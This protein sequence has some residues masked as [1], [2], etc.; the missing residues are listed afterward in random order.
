MQQLL[1]PVLHQLPASHAQYLT[2]RSF[3]P[4]LITQPF[5][6]GLT[7]AFAFAI[8]ACVVAAIASALTGRP[9]ANTH[10]TVGG[11]LAEAVGMPGE[12]SAPGAPHAAVAAMAHKPATE[13]RSVGGV[14]ISG[15]VYG[16]D[17][18]PVTG[19]AVTLI[20]VEGRQLGRSI[21]QGDGSFAIDVP[22]RGSYVLIASA[23]GYQPQA[24][25]IVIADTPVS[26]DILLIGGRSSLAGSVRSADSGAPITG[27]IVVVTDLRGDVLATATTDE[28]GEFT[29]I[30]LVQG[31]VT[32]AIGSPRYR[33]SAQ[34]VEIAGVGTTRIEVELRPGAH[35]R[36]TVRAGEAP[37]SDARVTLVDNAGNVI[38]TITTGT[39]GRYAFSD[40]DAGTYTVIATGYPPKAS[41]L[42]VSGGGV[43]D[44]DIELAHS[45]DQEPRG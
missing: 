4:H 8:I 11:E 17:N 2:G 44:H 43:D 30:D 18:G 29:V 39:D 1:G 20:S 10:E 19:A 9:R 5:S 45:E 41:E 7:V 15:R 38:A 27:A 21:A 16:I 24:S 13:P 40:L 37:L 26:H 12:A 3:F 6:D 36:G 22:G 25:S 34:T 33:P 35:V 23:E 31:P 14:P 28:K 42:T 32:V